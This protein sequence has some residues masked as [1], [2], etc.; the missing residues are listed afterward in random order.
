MPCWIRGYVWVNKEGGESMSQTVTSI[1][2]QNKNASSSLFKR[3]VRKF[4][5]NKLALFGLVV[6][7]VITVVC[8]VGTRNRYGGP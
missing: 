5:N 6:V 4:M 1:K 3:N 7:V 2:E 8:I